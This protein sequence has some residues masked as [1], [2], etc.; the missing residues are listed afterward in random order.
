LP[1]TQTTTNGGCWC[2]TCRMASGRAAPS[3]SA[4]SGCFWRRSR[5]CTRTTGTGATASKDYRLRRSAAPR[6]H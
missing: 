6:P 5:A 4:T 3:R 1:S 2:A